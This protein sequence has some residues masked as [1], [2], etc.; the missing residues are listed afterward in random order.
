MGDRPGN[1]KT[2]LCLNV[3]SLVCNIV[4]IILWVLVLIAAIVI[5]IL[6]ITIFRH[7]N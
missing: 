7:L 2:A 6:F 1:K 4:G 3:A 5:V